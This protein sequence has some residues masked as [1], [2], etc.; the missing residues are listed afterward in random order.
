MIWSRCSAHPCLQMRNVFAYNQ[1]ITDLQLLKQKS[2]LLE[3]VI[4][5]RTC[6]KEC[7]SAALQYKHKG[8]LINNPKLIIA[9]LKNIANDLGL[10]Y[11]IADGG[12]VFTLFGKIFVI[13]IELDGGSIKDAK[14]TCASASNDT[15]EVHPL[16]NNLFKNLLTTHRF[17]KFR[18]TVAEIAFLDQSTTKFKIDLF[19]CMSCLELDLQN[20]HALESKSSADNPFQVLCHGHGIPQH[21]IDKFFPKISFWANPKYC[22]ADQETLI[23]VSEKLIVGIEKGVG[24]LL[25]LPKT[26]K[27]FIISPNK[28]NET[29]TGTIIVD[30]P[31]FN[32]V[33]RM[34]QSQE[35]NLQPFTFAFTF[36]NPIVVTKAVIEQLEIYNL[37]ERKPTKFVNSSSYYQ[38][39]VPK[40]NNINIL[41]TKI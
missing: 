18:E 16:V 3:R 11:Y 6:M 4:K 21:Y 35:M 39:I 2:V 23:N 1:I 33:V 24:N 5:H 12:Q 32:G 31:I 41:G 8:C 14:F 34:Y 7:L 38:F 29:P 27:Q 28:S 19:H 25:M 26:F 20:I 37:S 40:Q 30:V 17:Q 9:E 10:S 13:D 22:N 15:H 36:D